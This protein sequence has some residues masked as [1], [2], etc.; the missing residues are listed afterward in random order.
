MQVNALK[1]YL[2]PLF[3]VMVQ[4]PTQSTCTSFQGATFACLGARWPYSLLPHFDFDFSQF[5]GQT[6]LIKFPTT[7]EVETNAIEIRKYVMKIIL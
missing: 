5:I 6:N 7:A 4:G 1:T 2:A 3:A